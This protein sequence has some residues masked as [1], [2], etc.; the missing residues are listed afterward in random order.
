MAKKAQQSKTEIIARQQRADR[1]SYR[2][3]KA[4]TE[5]P[6]RLEAREGPR[7]LATTRGGDDR[8]HHEGHGL[9]AA[10]GPR[11]LCRRRSQEARPYP[12]IREGG[13]RTHLSRCRRQDESRYGYR[14][15]VGLAM[16][17]R[18]ID[19]AAIEAEVD[20]VRSLGIDAL[21]RRWRTMFGAVPPKGL[22]KDI[23]ARM[24]A[25]RIQE[26]AF[27]GLDKETVRLLDRLA[28]GEKLSEAYR[29]LKAGTVLVRE[30]MGE[31]HTV[32]VVPD[33]FL[34]AGET[35]SSLSVIAQA[36]TGTKWN[37]PRFSDCV[38]HESPNPRSPNS[39]KIASHLQSI[40][41]G[42]PR[43]EPV[44]ESIAGGLPMPPH[45][46]DPPLRIYTRKSTDD[47]LDLDF[48]SFDAQREACEAYIKGQAHEGW[49]QIPNHYDDG[50][51]SGG[52]P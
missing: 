6:S 1:K 15:P 22:T 49:R 9:A 17:Q 26:E 27:G 13:R 4:S 47:G 41:A 14:K 29:R 52:L 46:E 28:R 20:Q 32:T 40:N 50:A 42:G 24:I 19:P 51:F 31:R 36:I 45:Q 21:R 5:D 39:R 8:R 12:Q 25:Y 7:S 48:I 37:G 34:W 33:G 11:L 16:D 2:S 44:R 43:S 35:Y 23:I 18:S 38:W 10:F 30:Y 3:E